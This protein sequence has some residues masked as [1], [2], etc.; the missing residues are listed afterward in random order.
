MIQLVFGLFLLG[1]GAAS[2]VAIFLRAI[3]GTTKSQAEISG[4]FTLWALAIIASAGGMLL[5]DIIPFHISK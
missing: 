5:L 4:L 2:G 1:L 3:R